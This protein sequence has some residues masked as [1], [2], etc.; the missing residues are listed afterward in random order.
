MHLH[1]LTT[2]EAQIIPD[3]GLVVTLYDLL[4]VQ[5]GHIYPSDGAAHYEVQGSFDNV[6]C[7][8]LFSLSVC[9]HAPGPAPWR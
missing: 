7:L 2:A 4:E 8:T 6:Q 1:C 3:V 9:Q 5:G